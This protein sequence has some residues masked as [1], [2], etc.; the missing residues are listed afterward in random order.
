MRLRTA[1]DPVIAPFSHNLS[2]S[3]DLEAIPPH[4]EG[5]GWPPDPGW[6]GV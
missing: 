6:W 5:G 4:R 3:R 1:A 2:N